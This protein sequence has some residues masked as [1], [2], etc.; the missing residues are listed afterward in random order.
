MSVWQCVNPSHQSVCL[1]LSVHLSVHQSVG[2]YVWSVHPAF[3]PSVCPSVSL[4][5]CLSV[6]LLEKRFLNVHSVSLSLCLSVSLSLRLFISVLACLYF[7]SISLKKLCNTWKV[8]EN[9]DKIIKGKRDKER[10]ILKM[11]IYEATKVLFETL[12]GKTCLNN[13]VYAIK[14]FYNVVR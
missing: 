7:S 14:P 11:I 3:N 9:I 1:Y 12:N 4:Y 13:M 2:L 6:C 10:N 5:N 8:T